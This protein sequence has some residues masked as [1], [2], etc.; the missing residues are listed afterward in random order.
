MPPYRSESKNWRASPRGNNIRT[1]AAESGLGMIASGYCCRGASLRCCALGMFMRTPVDGI[2][3]RISE[4][5]G[6]KAK[7]HNKRFWSFISRRA[8]FYKTDESRYEG[9]GRF[10]Y[11]EVWSFW[12]GLV[13]I[14]LETLLVLSGYARRY[15]LP[16]ET[17]FGWIFVRTLS[18]CFLQSNK[19]VLAP[20]V[21]PVVGNLCGYGSQVV[22]L[23]L[24]GETAYFPV[25]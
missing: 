9:S 20:F 25:N 6:R 1:G 19:L 8:V 5:T 22:V 16:K 11:I 15:L 17:P 3:S 24:M 18:A 2:R 21:C 14:I 13:Y 12:F 4:G 23:L 7:Y 10:L